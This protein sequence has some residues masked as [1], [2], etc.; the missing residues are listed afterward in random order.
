MMISVTKLF[1]V[2]KPWD[3]GYKTTDSILCHSSS[4]HLKKPII[5]LELSK[6]LEEKKK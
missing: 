3:D 6:N 2:V 1:F 5:I 4:G